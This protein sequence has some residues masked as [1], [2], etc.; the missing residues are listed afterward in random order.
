MVTATKCNTIGA[1]TKAFRYAS[2]FTV[3][4]FL[5]K[6]SRSRAAIETVK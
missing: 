3:A 1:E 6:A 4:I 2:F 5:S